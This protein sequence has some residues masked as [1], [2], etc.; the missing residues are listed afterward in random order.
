M[1]HVFK[2]HGGPVL[3]KVR[4]N[5]AKRRTLTKSYECLETLDK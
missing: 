4:T 2:Q 1:C 3:K 5:S